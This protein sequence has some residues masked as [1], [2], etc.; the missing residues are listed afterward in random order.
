MTGQARDYTQSKSRH[1]D[2][3]LNGAD[4]FLSVT[5]CMSSESKLLLIRGRDLCAGSGE[6]EGP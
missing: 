3:S 1:V 5:N 4:C 6:W 2:D